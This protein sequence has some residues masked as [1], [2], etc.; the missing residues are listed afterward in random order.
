MVPVVRT[1]GS[2]GGARTRLQKTSID[3]E[4]RQR[5][6]RLTRHNLK[7][8]LENL[9]ARAG[10]ALQSCGVLRTT[11]YMEI[12]RYDFLPMKT[13]VQLGLPLNRSPPV[14]FHTK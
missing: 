5:T 6:P 8:R 1:A 2:A 11:V 12:Q 13:T 4:K 9:K 14:L 10:M 3:D 7:A